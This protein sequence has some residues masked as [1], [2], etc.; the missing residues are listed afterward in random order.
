MMT[1]KA[2]VNLRDSREG[3]NRA[4]VASRGQLPP[5][6]TQKPRDKSFGGM[7]AGF[8]NSP[9]KPMPEEHKTRD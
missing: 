9:N 5:K 6:D 2:P 8:L 7:Q 3:N 1:P 4:N